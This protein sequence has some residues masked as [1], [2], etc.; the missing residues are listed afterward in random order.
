MIGGHSLPFQ[1]F[2]NNYLFILFLCL[3]TM[4]KSQGIII[5]N[6]KIFG[7][8]LEGRFF[9]KLCLVWRVD[10]PVFT[11]TVDFPCKFYWGGGGEG[12]V[13]LSANGKAQSALLLFLLSLGG[14]KGC[15][16][17]FPCFPMCSHSVPPKFLMGSQ[18][19]P[20]V[21]PRSS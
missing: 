12:F 18:Y 13:C 8:R 14:R 10:C 9:F 5:F 20:I 6:Y 1:M 11:W 15:F 4:Y 2:K 7:G 3:F 16:F 19:V 21:F 17:I